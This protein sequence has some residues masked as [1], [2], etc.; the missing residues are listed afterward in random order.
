VTTPDDPA[1]GW[2]AIEGAAAAL[3]P[4]QEPVHTAYD[5]GLAFGSGLQGCS[6]YQAPEAWHYVTFGQSE[7]WVKEPDGDPA[8][9]GWGYELTMRIA[10]S[11]EAAPPAWPFVLLERLGR[12]TNESGRPFG[13]G[14]RLDLGAPLNGDPRSALRALAVAA[15]L[16][17]GPI[18]TPNGR[19]E[20]RQ[21]VGITADELDEMKA[22]TTEAVLDRLRVSNPT[23]IT[24][25]A[26]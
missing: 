14:H 16:D 2:D 3:Y 20:F 8:V 22:S 19:V 5:P 18:D 6:A 25:P 26:R 9:S 7:L 21:L 24:D 13:I 17:L 23:L 4:D 11:D 1:P 10:R 12:H 15:D